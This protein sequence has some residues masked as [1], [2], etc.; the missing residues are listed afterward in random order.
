MDSATAEIFNAQLIA[1]LGEEQQ[2]KR[3]L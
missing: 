1:G 2:L 3:P